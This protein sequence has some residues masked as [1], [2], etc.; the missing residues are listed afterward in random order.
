MSKLLEP[1][2]ACYAQGKPERIAE[3]FYNPETISGELMSKEDIKKLPQPLYRL[4]KVTGAIN[5][6]RNDKTLDPAI[7]LKMSHILDVAGVTIDAN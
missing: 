3:D 7:R 4:L 6:L 1:K 2:P 5:E